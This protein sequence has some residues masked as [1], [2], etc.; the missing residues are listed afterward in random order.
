VYENIGQWRVFGHKRLNERKKMHV[1]L[2]VFP[3]KK[4]YWNEQIKRGLDWL[5]K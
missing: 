5:D 3:P 2:D 4:F 1:Q